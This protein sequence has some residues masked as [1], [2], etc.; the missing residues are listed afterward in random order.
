MRA[1]VQ[2]VSEARVEVSGEVIGQCGNGLLVL[3]ATHAEDTEKDAVKLADRVFG[4]RIFNDDNGKM[5]LSL[6]DVS[7]SVL[8]IS[9]FTLYGEAMKNRRP[10]FI[11]SASFS[12]GQTLYDKFVEEFR[13]LTPAVETGVFGADMQVHLVNDGPVTIM[14][15]TR[16]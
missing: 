8:I 4:M 12:I 9:N 10:S 16:S 15:D 13:K 7:G 6:T 1:I 14:L 5:N 11:G 3:V 2:R